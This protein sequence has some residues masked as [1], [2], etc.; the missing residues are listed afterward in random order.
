MV[1]GART[2]SLEDTF[3]GPQI[4]NPPPTRHAL[5][6]FLVAL[7]AIL[8]IG[9]AAWGDLYDN[10]EGEIAGRAR[11]MLDSR[12]WL[13]PTENGAPALQRPPLTYWI[14]ATSCKIF[15]VTATAIR[16]PIAL[17]L[18]GSV[19]FTF[20][21]GERLAGYWRGFAA[22]LIHL[23]SIGGFLLGRMATPSVFV[24]LFV[25]A[26]IYC[27]VR[28][29]LHRKFRRLWYAGFWF[30]G[31]LACLTAGLHAIL[32][33]AGICILL[34]IFY[35]EARARFLPLLHWSHL[36]LFLLLTAPWFVWAQ[37]HFPGFWF[38]ARSGD[39][40][41]AFARI[42]G[43]YLA[44][45]F[46]ALFLLLPALALAPRKIF[47]PHELLPPDALPLF[48]LALAIVGTLLLGE[49]TEHS[50]LIAMPGFALFAASAWERTSRPMRAV[51]I[52]CALVTGLL[53][54]CLVAFAPGILENAIGRYFPDSFWISMRPLA[55]AALAT[56]LIFSTFALIIVTRQRAEITLLVVIGAMAPIGF[57]LAEARSRAAP[58]FSLADAARFLNP[59]L[60]GNGEVIFEGSVKSGSSLT[61][62]LDK[63]F[64]LLNQMPGPLERDADS[65]RK[66][67]DEHFLLEAW[68]RSNPIY[69]IIDES[70]VSYWRKRI[71]QRVHIYHQVTTCGPRVILSN[72]L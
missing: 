59:R 15:G 17:A 53:F 51:G 23:C 8:H 26:A 47:R 35:R 49:R 45:W 42:L 67:L 60:A 68:D 10:T 58:F 62:Y 25:S 66:Y 33:P 61:F 11:A 38:G 63:K 50:A 69:L 30:C 71:T 13:V 27:A 36:V 57:C 41:I 7:A 39:F 14:L 65:Q 2:L 48:W 3:F 72:E 24:T 34:A 31:S 16:I 21:L 37:L 28:G 43:S 5:L 70:R 46:P 20:L 40:G 1:A 4:L 64:Y 55:Q 29:Y 6:A 9:T 19:A 18:V 12:D 32:F 52:I 44:S 56:L 22:G 54:L